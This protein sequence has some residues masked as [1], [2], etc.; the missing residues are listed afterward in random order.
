MALSVNTNIASL[1]AQRNLAKT[2]LSLGT[3]LERLSSGL[4]I[5]SAAD[6]AAGMAISTGLTAQIN[7]MNQAVRNANDGLSLIGTAD[8]AISQQTD[9]LQRMRE[10]AVQSA[11]DT[12]SNDNRTSLNNE[13][14]QL[15]AELDRIANTTQFNGNNL[16]DGTFQNKDLQVGA[17]STA[18][19]RIPISIGSTKAADLGSAYKATSATVTNSAMAAGDV[20]LTVGGSTYAVGASTTDGVSTVGASVSALAKANAINTVTNKTGVTAEADT[21]VTGGSAQTAGSIA[22][23]DLVINGITVGAVTLTGASDQ[24]LVAA[25]NAKFAQTGVTASLDI[26]NKLVLDAAD[27]RNITV[28]SA[29]TTFSGF[30]N[31]TTTSYGTLT[32]RS[33]SGFLVGGGAVA[34]A[35]LTAGAATLATSENINTLDMSTQSGAA[36]AIKEI[37]VALS[38]LDTSRASIGALTNRLNSTVS[39]LS[40]AAENATASNS[41]IMDADFAQETANMSRNQVLQQAGV[42]ILAQA[43]AAPQLALKL[44]QG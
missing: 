35:G 16:L 2:S 12:N 33:T 32:L 26:N 11:S 38:Q 8:S 22:D 39:A 24:S 34:H 13:T 29:N 14:S 17:F 18:N 9:L 43:N 20:T 21:T 1:N 36:L 23:G 28:I 25:I 10:L 7:G 40:S 4:R 5:N 19:D 42:A 6:D 27:G 31:A 30:A 41:R 37:D 3:S 15:K 44:L